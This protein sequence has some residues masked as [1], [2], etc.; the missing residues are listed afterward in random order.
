MRILVHSGFFGVQKLDEDDG[1]EGYILTDASR[2]L[3]KDNPLSVT[4]FLLAMLDPTLNQPWHH[5][6]TWFQNDDRTPFKTANG[7]AFWEYAGHN[8]RLNNL[9]NDAMESDT[10]LVTSVVMEKC[11]GVFERL[12]SLVDDG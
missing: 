2:L 12:E 5:L 7:M 6:S 10:R 3:L 11:K 1:E 9:F 8:T 4:P